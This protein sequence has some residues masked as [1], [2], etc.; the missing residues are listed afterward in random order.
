MTMLKIM[1][2]T[3]GDY[4]TAQNELIVD[5]TKTDTGV[6]RRFALGLAMLVEHEGMIISKD[7]LKQM[8]V[9]ID[10]RAYPK[11]ELKSHKLWAGIALNR[12]IK[13]GIAVET[14]A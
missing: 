10:A 11:Q 8:L 2:T 3:F 5:A 6:F 13:T 7:K 1:P 9:E 4:V 12:M 14:N